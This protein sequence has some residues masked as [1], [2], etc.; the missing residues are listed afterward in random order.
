[1]SVTTVLD[2]STVLLPRGLALDAAGN[3]YVADSGHGRVIRRSPDGTVVTLPF[4]GLGSWSGAS[5][6]DVGGVISVVVDTA[7]N[8]F[9]L[10]R[11][12]GRVHKLSPAAP[13]AITFTSTPPIDAAVGGSYTVSATG[14]GSGNPVTFSVDATS[15]GACTL[16]G[17]TI[18]FAHAGLCTINANQA[19][20][21][22]FAAAPQV[23]RRSAVR[24]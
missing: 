18:A 3:L 12:P 17:A 16:A 1:L 4:V 19:G 7:G 24:S 5:Q 9:A 23:Q 15:A 11:G 10:D 6:G 13:Q 14:G 20:S 21:Y 22:T 2:S 8:I